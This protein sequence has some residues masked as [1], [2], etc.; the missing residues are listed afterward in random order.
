M[1]MAALQRLPNRRRPIAAGAML[2]VL[3]ALAAI[4]T[5]AR[6][7]TPIATRNLPADARISVMTYNVEGLPFPARIGRSSSLDQIGL[8]LHEMRAA[9]RQPHIVA[10]QETFSDV[11]KQIGVQAGYRY[12]VSG[13]SAEMAARKLNNGAETALASSANMFKGEGI[14]KYFDSG[15]MILSDYPV[16]S[17]RR[18]AFPSCAGFDCMAN[19]GAVMA[20]IAVPGVPAPVAVVDTHLNSRAASRAQFDRS[21][22][23]YKQQIEVLGRFL[24]ANLTPSSPLII[25]GDFN[26]GKDRYR[27]AYLE[28]HFANW[29]NGATEVGVRDSLRRCAAGEEGCD[30][31]MPADAF[32]TLRRGKDWQIS[33]PALAS[34]IL[35]RAISV[36]FGRES[37]GSMLSDHMGYVVHYRWQPGGG[38]RL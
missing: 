3:L 5:P 18:V 11:A 16:L 26:V 33:A 12:I 25:A 17:V 6:G 14:G 27:S 7:N 29:W 15:L 28:A 34:A 32:R 31:N 22:V 23:A 38:R 2:L 1:T 21:L 36:P 4:L 24:Q 30:P 9:G 35:P 8:R 10:L 20:F 19:K 37:D 13:P